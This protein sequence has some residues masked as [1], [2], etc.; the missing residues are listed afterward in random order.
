MNRQPGAGVLWPLA[1]MIVALLLSACTLVQPMAAGDTGE[2]AVAPAGDELPLVGAEWTLVSLD[3]SMGV[4]FDAAESPV[5]IAFGEDGSVSGS[6]GC[7]R[8][9]GGYTDEGDTLSFTPL[10]TTRMMCAEA[11][12]AV[13]LAVLNALQG[14]VPYT[15]D[16]STL[17][18]STASGALVFEGAVAAAKGV[19]EGSAAADADGAASLPLYGT[20]WTLVSFDENMSVEFDAAVTTV[21]A[22]FTEDGQINGTAGCNNYFGGF[23][24]DGTLLTFEPMGSTMMMCEEPAM[25]VESSFL[26]ALEGEALYQVNGDTLELITAGGTLTFAGAPADEAAASEDAPLTG[27]TWGLISLDE[28]MGVAFD[29]AETTVAMTFSDDGTVSG[30]GGCN[31]FSGGYTLDGTMVTFGAI[32]STLMACADPASSVEQAVFSALQGEAQAQISG[33]TLKLITGVGTLTF[34]EQ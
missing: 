29:P 15:I 21:T 10:A 22:N 19:D 34:E 2:P 7:N 16:G 9:N 25:A 1:I 12:M 26:G 33:N 24:I 27:T 6:A 20:E 8:F 4:A 3:E 28:N 30:N 11:Q 23:T 18:L 14:S 5:S 13:E 32:A 31:N 17:T